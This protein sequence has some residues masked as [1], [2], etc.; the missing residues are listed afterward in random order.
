MILR[1]RLCIPCYDNPATIVQVVSDALQQTSFA[2]LVVDDGSQEPVQALL[3]QDFSAAAALESGRLKVLRFPENRGKGVAIR[4][5]IKD[6][7]ALGF[8]HLLT[9]DGDGQ[10]LVSDASKLVALAEQF[11]W[12]LII[13]QRRMEAASVPESSR[14]GRKFS[15]FWVKYQTGSKIHDSQS[16]FRLYPL[17]H[18]QCM[19][20]LTRRYEF[21]IEV[22][23][24]LLWKGVTVREVEIDVVYPPGDERV[25]HFRKFIDNVRISLLNTALVV[26]SLLRSHRA[27]REVGFALGLGVMIGCTPLYGLHTLLAAALAF[28]FRLNAG[29]LILGSNI[30]IPPLA[31]FLIG[32]SLA[33][34]SYLLTGDAA[35]ALALPKMVLAGRSD[36]HALLLLAGAS[37]KAWALGSLV[38]GTAL[39][40][41]FGC[42]A[43]ALTWRLQRGRAVNWTG[44]TRG[45]VWGNA[46]LAWVLRTLGLRAGYACLAFLIPYYY[47]FAPRARRAL[48]EYW[49]TVRPEATGL[50]RVALILRHLR[51]F[52][53]VLMDR[54]FA[55]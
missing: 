52:G 33:I 48:H 53:Q 34:G 4:A 32:G 2:V 42:S 9:L 15:N 22:L 6:S 21:E 19:A 30:S 24:R 10:H 31:P 20:F 41:V 37:V 18:V 44:R 55:S 16:G 14:F 8:T 13:G 38:L 7:V 26:V 29:Y 12:D 1:I 54:V 47:V 17:F 49:A 27:P 43:F 36:L 39:G 51:R 40:L 46:I 50:R 5:A 25:S 45:G 11:P 23:I 28:A 3:A 35:A